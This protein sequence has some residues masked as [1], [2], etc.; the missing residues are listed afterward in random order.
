MLALAK[1]VVN[2]QLHFS[3]FCG[4]G[5]VN[6]EIDSPSCKTLAYL[7]GA[8]QM[9]SREEWRMLVRVLPS[10]V[11]VLP[12]LND[13]RVP[14]DGYVPC[15]CESDANVCALRVLSISSLATQ[16][17]L[18]YRS[19]TYNFLGVNEVQNYLHQNTRALRPAVQCC[20]Y[21]PYRIRI[22]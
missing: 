11:R 7:Q 18:V 16:C 1:W 20:I 2:S 4:L 22:T 9:S 12:S 14:E 13:C 17:T 19:A 8:F 15:E 21:I 3:G 5:R 6:A 10:Y